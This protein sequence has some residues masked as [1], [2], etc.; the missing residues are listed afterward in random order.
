MEVG[1]AQRASDA[2]VEQFV[3]NGTGENSDCLAISEA[4]EVLVRE[5]A[6][7]SDK[8]LALIKKVA[9][10]NKELWEI[11]TQGF[12]IIGFMEVFKLPGSLVKE[13]YGQD[14]S[15]DPNYRNLEDDCYERTV[16]VWR[17]KVKQKSAF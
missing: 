16:D 14:P 8:A 1:Y 9:P 3:I 4:V 10:T 7:D 6:L 2:I 12:T 5:L 11:A 13:V 15:F 17:P